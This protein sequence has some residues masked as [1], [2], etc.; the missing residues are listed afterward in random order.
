M[1]IKVLAQRRTRIV[2]RIWP[3]DPN[4]PLITGPSLGD[5]RT[6]YD[7]IWACDLKESFWVQRSL[8]IGVLTIWTRSI[9]E[10]RY[11]YS[12]SDF[13]APLTARPASSIFLAP[14]DTPKKILDP[15][16]RYFLKLSVISDEECNIH[17]QPYYR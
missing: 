8:N 3:R 10:Y 13:E 2:T 16:M 15:R 6:Q 4:G 11:S 7:L 5:L 12:E 9:K 14:S 1:P 17:D